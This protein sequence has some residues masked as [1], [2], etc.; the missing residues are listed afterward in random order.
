MNLASGQGA[1]DVIERN[2]I[3]DHK[4]K[5]KRR[6]NRERKKGELNAREWENERL[7]GNP[8]SSLMVAKW[9]DIIGLIS[10]LGIRAT[11]YMH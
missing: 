5:K 9:R 8:L 4:K 3:E 10:I 2:E 11:L 7:P 6:K 1:P